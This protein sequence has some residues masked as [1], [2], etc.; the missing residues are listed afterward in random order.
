MKR[1]YIII[2]RVNLDELNI[3]DK[4]AKKLNMKR[5]E[6]IR[7]LILKNKDVLQSI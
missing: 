1:N 2:V 4:N 7:N 5:S 6:Y 3:V